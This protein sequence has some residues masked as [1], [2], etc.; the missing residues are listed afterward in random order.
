MKYEGNV[1]QLAPLKSPGLLGMVNLI[2]GTLSLVTIA[3]LV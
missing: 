1:R 3:L 2:L